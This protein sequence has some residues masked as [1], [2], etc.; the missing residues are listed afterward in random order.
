MGRITFCGP[1]GAAKLFAGVGS[2]FGME[3]SELGMDGSEELG[4]FMRWLRIAF[5][6]GITDECSSTLGVSLAALAW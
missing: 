1:T 6:S 5:M 4:R 3:G 2:G